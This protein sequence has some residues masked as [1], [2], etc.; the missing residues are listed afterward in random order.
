ML[1][2]SGRYHSAD[3][4]IATILAVEPLKF[5]Y[6]GRISVFSFV[7]LRD[8]R[9]VVVAEQKQGVNEEDCFNWM[10]RVVQ[11]IDS[12]H[13]VSIYCIAF[14]PPNGLPKVLQ[15]LQ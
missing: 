1:H 15:H 7:L 6:R 10:M 4:L 12:I 3:D 2:V 5:I 11:A 8:E 14:V 13:H 9:I